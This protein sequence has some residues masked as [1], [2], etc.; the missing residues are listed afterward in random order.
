MKLHFN[1]TYLAI[2]II[3]LIIEILIAKY[4]KTGFIRHTFGDFLVVILMYCFFKSFLEINSLK[5][6]IS[7]LIF[8]FIIEFLQ[9]ANLLSL[10]NLQNNKFVSIVLG[11]TFNVTDLIAY[12]LGI[13]ITLIIEFQSQ[14][15]C[16]K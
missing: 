11:S 9:L 4:L 12:T 15:L 8:S 16:T 1:K 13:I 14:K 7:V 2:T 6:A 10:L 5:L 3:L